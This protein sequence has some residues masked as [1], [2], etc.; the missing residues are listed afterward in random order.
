MYDDREIL[1]PVTLSVLENSRG[2][3]CRSLLIFSP[4]YMLH[5]AHSSPFSAPLSLS[6]STLSSSTLLIPFYRRS[7]SIYFT[8]VYCLNNLISPVLPSLPN[9][10]RV[11][12]FTI[13]IP[14]Q[15]ITSPI[16]YMPNLPCTLPLLLPSTLL[17]PQAP[18]RRTRFHCMGPRP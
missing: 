4:V 8:F 17:T 7:L 6:L 3:L 12:C 14:P 9:H 1:K 2:I 10:L 18:L 5:L 15:F 11:L 13:F 16:F